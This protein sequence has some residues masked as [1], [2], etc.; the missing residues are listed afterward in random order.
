MYELFYF[1]ERKSMYEICNIVNDDTY[2]SSNFFRQIGTL[3]YQ[4]FLQLVAF[5]IKLNSR[6]LWP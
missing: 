5:Y 2:N 4:F 3:I 1:F 6:L